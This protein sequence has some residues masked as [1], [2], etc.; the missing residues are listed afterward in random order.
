MTPEILEVKVK[1][2]KLKQEIR[3]QRSNNIIECKKDSL[4]IDSTYTSILRILEK[5]TDNMIEE[6]NGCK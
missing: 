6:V 5:I 3:T 2:N 1:L 4:K